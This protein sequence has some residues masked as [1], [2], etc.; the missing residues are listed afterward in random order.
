MPLVIPRNIVALS[1]GERIGGQM[2]WWTIHEND[3]RLG[4]ITNA[5]IQVM[6]ENEKN[7]LVHSKTLPDF[8]SFL[9]DTYAD[10]DEPHI[11]EERVYCQIL[12]GQTQSES[13]ERDLIRVVDIADEV[14]EKMPAIE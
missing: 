6:K 7:V 3:E 10:S 14:I 2:G 9:K 8:V 12:L 13:I 1:I 11:L 4:E 5:I